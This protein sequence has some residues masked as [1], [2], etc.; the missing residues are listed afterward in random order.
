M[1][2]GCRVMGKTFDRSSIEELE[3]SAGPTCLNRRMHLGDGNVNSRRLKTHNPFKN[4]QIL[5]EEL[6][7]EHGDPMTAS[8]DTLNVEFVNI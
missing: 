2:F 7:N 3:A 5:L 4:V 8:A 1:E 6:S